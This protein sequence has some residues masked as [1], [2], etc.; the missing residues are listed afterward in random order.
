VPCPYPSAEGPQDKTPTHWFSTNSPYSEEAIITQLH[1]YPN[2]L[3]VMAG[4]RHV[5]TVTAHPSDNRAHPERGFWEVE[6]ASLRDFP[7]NFRTF[8]ILRNRDNSISILTT[9]VDPQV[10]AG[11]PEEKS[12]GYAIAAS[13]LFGNTTLG[14]TSPLVYNAELVK[15]LTPA[16]QAK[17]AAYGTAL[18]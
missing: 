12:L 3:L 15:L 8:S 16:M 13:R 17:I 5:N 1:K 11:S 14:D 4:H 10:R 7:R 18:R 9:D 2:L 6:T